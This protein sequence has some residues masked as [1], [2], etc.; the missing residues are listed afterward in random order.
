[1]VV[2][3]SKVKPI[4]WPTVAMAEKKKIESRAP[5][6]KFDASASDAQLENM[7]NVMTKLYQDGHDDIKR[8]IAK[9]FAES[10]GG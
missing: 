8:K 2:F 3:S 9:S 6:I 4:T 5:Q 10:R 1:V 7:I